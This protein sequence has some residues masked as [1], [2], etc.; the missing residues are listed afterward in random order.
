MRRCLLLLIMALL[1][2]ETGA[3]KDLRTVVV[4]DPY[5]EMHTGP[6]G[7]YPV[8]TVVERG[9]Q[10]AVLK[11]RTTW[12]L[13]REPRGRE[14]WVAEEQLRK[15]LE[16]TGGPIG[17]GETSLANLAKAH[18]QGG[19]MLG[20]F[21]GASIISLFGSYG[22]STHLSIAVTVSQALGNISNAEIATLDLTH[23]VAPEWRV[24]PYLSIGAGVIHSSPHTTQIQEVDSTDQMSFVGAGLRMY[25]TR[26]FT[27]RAEYRANYTFTSRD[28][29]EETNEWQA[30]FGFFF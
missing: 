22:L 12:Y 27:A 5:L 20:D 16:L 30:G 29:N 26:K 3:A 6:G 28:G 1:A 7:G 8:F 18:W 21:G 25:L 19:I 13:V 15:T 9:A 11:R 2:V 10:V 23:T 17:L 14:G 24:S 4:A